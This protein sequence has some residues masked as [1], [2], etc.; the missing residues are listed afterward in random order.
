MRGYRGEHN[1]SQC[2]KVREEFHRLHCTKLKVLSICCEWLQPDVFIDLLTACCET[3]LKLSFYFG[4]SKYMR[5]ADYAR[6]YGLIGQ[7]MPQLEK[8]L[9]LQ[10][11]VQKTTSEL[12]AFESVWQLR[13]LRQL[14][15]ERLRGQPLDGLKRM[16]TMHDSRLDHLVL[17]NVDLRELALLDTIGSAGNRLRVLEFRWC[18]A[19]E[20]LLRLRWFRWMR[21]LRELH[22]HSFVANENVDALLMDGLQYCPKLVSV[23]LMVVPQSPYMNKYSI[24]RD[25]RNVVDTVRFG[26]GIVL[27]WYDGTREVSF[28]Y[29]L[30]YV[31][32]VFHLK[33]A[34]NLS[35]V[36]NIRGY[37]F[38][39]EA[40]KVYVK[41]SGDVSNI[42]KHLE[43][44]EDYIVRSRTMF[45]NE[46][47]Y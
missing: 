25:L 47:V 8:L 35:F 3:L 18:T 42:N 9:V 1:H 38:N 10:T 27:Y 45:R 44:I 24:A 43:P 46:Y 39:L 13:Q 36:Q 34:N 12:A 6:F 19:I 26:R 28:L 21:E 32:L 15:L 22:V 37:T 23:T 4:E 20:S 5:A 41:R 11:D 17:V 33:Y 14:Q 16:I 29:W 2:A 30:E 31:L 7:R 40:L